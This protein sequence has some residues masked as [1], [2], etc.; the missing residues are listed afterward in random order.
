MRR[1]PDQEIQALIVDD[2][3][4]A[5]E[6]LK[7][8]LKDQWDMR[9]VGEARSAK[10]A[11]KMIAEMHPNLIFLDIQMPGGSG[12]DLLESLEDPPSVIFVTAYDQFA[13]RAFE[14]NALDYLLKPIDPERLKEAI[15]RAAFRLPSFDAKGEVFSAADQVFLNTGKKAS[16]VSVSNIVAVLAERNYTNVFNVQ[17]ERFMVRSS[18]ADWERRLPQ[19]MFVLLDR[20]TIINRNH[21]QLWT[22]H[23]RKA[24][25]R[26]TGLETPIE[27]GR[28]AYT[29]FKEQII[30]PRAKI[31]RR[32]SR[33][34]E[35]DGPEPAKEGQNDLPEKDVD[36]VKS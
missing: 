29:R 7:D 36:A 19:D 6:N 20:S 28:A 15:R 27:L 25:V 9:V 32:K 33:I 34:G 3:R 17:G 5:R 12:F 2:E 1:N 21:I 18:L 31:R 26:M 16:C 4:L 24:E 23:S 11:E 10:E 14:V 22:L 8:L 13:I 35:E 30:A